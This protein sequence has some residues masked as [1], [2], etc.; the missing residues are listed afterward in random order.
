MSSK[1]VVLVPLVLL[2]FAALPT[3][4]FA[5][6]P[7]VQTFEYTQPYTLPSALLG[8]GFD[9]VLTPINSK[10]RFTL[11]ADQNG[12]PR[13]LFITGPNLVLLT[14]PNTGKSVQVNS[15]ASG[16]LT[17]EPG[18][19]YHALVQGTAILINAVGAVP[20]FPQFAF[21]KGKLDMIITPDFIT[22]QINSF[23]GV[24][25]DICS[26]LS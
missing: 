23:N 16:R 12:D 15:S 9:V 26:L 25:Q 20:G 3:R 10:A 14:N 22:L 24:V 21:T 11:F 5:D 2:V 7:S 1:R 17:L 19:T 6:K 18:P 13:V 8:C 4:V